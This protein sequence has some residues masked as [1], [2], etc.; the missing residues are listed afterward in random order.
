MSLIAGSIEFKINGEIYLAKGSFKF[1]TNKFKT[2]TI[3]GQDRVHGFKK[4]PLAPFIEGEITDSSDLDYDKV[5][6]LSNATITLSLNNGK[7][8]ILDQASFV[9]DGE[10]E[11]EEGSISVRFEGVDCSVV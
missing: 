5:F 4:M 2:E 6:T 1:S 8:I 3:L 10:V 11:T 7:V 9:G